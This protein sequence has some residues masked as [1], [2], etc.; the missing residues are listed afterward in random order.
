M[1]KKTG[2]I[3]DVKIS[4]KWKD[5]LDYF[6]NTFE[7]RKNDRNYKEGDEV[8]F[9]EYENF[10]KIIIN[11]KNYLVIQTQCVRILDLTLIRPSVKLW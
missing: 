6:L 8:I 10:K 11:I 9:H 4:S 2:V 1:P 3:H 5:Y 7:I